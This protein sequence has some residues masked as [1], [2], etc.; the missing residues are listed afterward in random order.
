M[1]QDNVVPFEHPNRIGLARRG[2]PDKSCAVSDKT[3][4]LVCPRC[5]AVLCFEAALL[6]LNSDVL[7][8]GCNNA[9]PVAR[10]EAVDLR[11]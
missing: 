1:S 11:R 9:I 7:C 3:A 5:G 10:P 4:E 8:A 6:P 2:S